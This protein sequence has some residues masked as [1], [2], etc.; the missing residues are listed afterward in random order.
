M[1]YMHCNE[2]HHEWE[3][4]GHTRSRC[5]WC[6][7]DGHVLEEKIPLE[8]MSEALSGIDKSGGKPKKHTKPNYGKP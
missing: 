2:C 5:D 7:S 4:V 1:P 6:G 3:T 8:L